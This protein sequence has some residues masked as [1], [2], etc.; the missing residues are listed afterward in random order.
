[1]DSNLSKVAFQNISMTNM[2]TST[3]TTSILQFVLCMAVLLCQN[4]DKAHAWPISCW[5]L[6]QNVIRR[7]IIKSSCI[8]MNDAPIIFLEHLFY[9]RV[10]N[11]DILVYYQ[12]IAWSIIKTPI[13][14]RP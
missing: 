1:M 7:K 3:S 11:S 13:Q 10:E 8:I 6:D 14:K 9:I 5:V 12:I 4:N 2:M